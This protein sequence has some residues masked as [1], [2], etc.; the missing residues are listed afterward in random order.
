MAVV[1]VQPE[2]RRKRGSS[3]ARASHAACGSLLWSSA[4]DSDTHLHL[5]DVRMRQRF[6]HAPRSH[7]LQRNQMA[8]GW[9]T[10]QVPCQV[11]TS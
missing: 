10:H 11:R 3:Q 2:T 4:S 5:H 1:A 9:H 8:R 7:A 6:V